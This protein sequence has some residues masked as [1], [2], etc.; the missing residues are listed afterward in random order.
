VIVSAPLLALDAWMAARSVQT[1]LGP[2]VA[3]F[4]ATAPLGR[5]AVL[6]TV[7]VFAAP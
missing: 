3:Q 4:V 7:K 5:S 1:G 6:L 2:A